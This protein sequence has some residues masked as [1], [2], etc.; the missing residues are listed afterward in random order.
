MLRVDHEFTSKKISTIEKF[1][2]RNLLAISNTSFT[3]AHF[4]I[5]IDNHFVEIQVTFS[6]KKDCNDF[7][8]KLSWKYILCCVRI[9]KNVVYQKIKQNV[10]NILK[11]YYQINS[12]Y[13]V[14]KFTQFSIQ[15]S[16]IA[17]IWVLMT[18]KTIIQIACCTSVKSKLIAILNDTNIII[19]FIFAQL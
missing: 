17:D 16:S 1:R 10:Q 4:R 11:Y 2:T 8:C 14:L 7:T 18:L 19:L 9:S 5:E 3:N 13:I 15:I 6:S 12:A